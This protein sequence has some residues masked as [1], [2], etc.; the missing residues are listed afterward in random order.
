MKR[1]VESFHFNISTM[2]KIL[3][4]KLKIKLAYYYYYYCFFNHIPKMF[5]A[6]R[7]FAPQSSI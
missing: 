5:L 4:K 6:I 3:K 2:M 7:A 1:F